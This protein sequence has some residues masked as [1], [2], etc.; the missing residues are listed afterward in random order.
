[1]LRLIDLVAGSYQGVQLLVL[2]HLVILEED[3][4]FGLRR[5]R[6]TNCE[7][8]TSF[9]ITIVLVRFVYCNP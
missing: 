7:Y 3:K 8:P 6:Q 9:Q 1:M 2:W 4:M 5:V